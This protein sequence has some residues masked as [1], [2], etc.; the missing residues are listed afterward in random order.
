MVLLAL[1]TT[2]MVQAQENL[3]LLDN[4][5]LTAY[6]E[7]SYMITSVEDWNALADYVASG[8]DCAGM[9]F[10]MTADLGTAETPVTKTMGCQTKKDDAKSR[11]RFAGVFDGDGHT[12]TVNL[13]SAETNKNYC[14]PFA[15][16]K[17][18]TIKNL[19]VAGTVTADG[20][21]ASGLVG[22]SGNGEGD[23]TCTI[24]NCH[25]S[26]EIVDN[27]EMFTN[28]KYPNHGGFVGITEGNATIT[29]CWFDGSFT[30]KDF[31][32][33][34]GFVGLT[35][36][37][38]IFNNCLFN[39]SKIDVTDN[40]YANAREFS[41]TV[42]GTVILND[43]YYVTPF[44]SDINENPQGKQIQTTQPTEYEYITIKASDNNTYYIKVVNLTVEGYGESTES[45]HWMFIAS[46][47]T[48]DL[49]PNEVF[50]LISEATTEYDLYR[51]NQSGA[52][53]EW[54]N[55]K[56]DDHKGFV[57][58]NGQGYLYAN[59]KDIVLSF[60][61]T[62]NEE[63]T[64]TVK[65]DYDNN[66]TKEGWN[67]IGNPFPVNA[68]LSTSYYVMNSTGSGL[69]AIAV[70]SNKA[71]A[72]CNGV[73]V[74][75]TAKNQK[76]TFS[77]EKPYQSVNQGNLQIAVAQA[78]TRDH[79]VLDKAIVS[80]NDNDE[81]TKYYF[82]ERNASLFIPRDGKEYAIASTEKQ[83]E[84]PVN[85]KAAQDG[86]YSISINPETVEMDY[87]Y[88]IDNLTG[89]Q[90]D[91]LTTPSYSFSAKTN[92]YA[93]RFRLVFSVQDNNEESTH[94][95]TVSNG[96]ISINGEGSAQVIDLMGHIVMTLGDAK[97]GITTSSMAPG[98]YTIRLINGENVKTQKII[99]K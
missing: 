78:N 91:L 49:N 99:I 21:F 74:Q 88:L 53:G 47:V 29:D 98:I 35:K 31:R 39:P 80:F 24:E 41:N 63:T 17:N 38:T 25:V 62:F 4:H 77:T 85:F 37:T 95:A 7:N 28:N 51:F 32:H 87:L 16:A 12:L 66:A 82:G 2:I 92:D 11:K 86:T 59:K 22:S 52:N 19:H 45:D 46:P 60:A 33:S 83:G 90:I 94:L 81:L 75:A 58:K 89:A 44:G 93:S 13:T 30:G 26:V 34:G 5:T 57:L 84:M 61:G 71:I 97:R 9:T 64:K 27:Y 73:M 69:E 65:L 14:A 15:Y 79:A 70:S 42:S 76:V 3:T 23:G 96:T 48:T 50:N 56:S 10:K 55:S 68:Y 67:L 54:E 6:A 20:Q 18:I 72:P 40:K 1:F 36:K 8:K 43:S